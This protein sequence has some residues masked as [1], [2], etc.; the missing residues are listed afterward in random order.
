MILK[1]MQQKIR[2]LFIFMLLC[3]D[4]D[5][6]KNVLSQC[7]CDIIITIIFANQ[8]VYCSMCHN[9]KATYIYVQHLFVVPL[10]NM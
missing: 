1:L 8:N 5:A 9:I 6:P 4:I 7:V 2:N 3:G 10:I